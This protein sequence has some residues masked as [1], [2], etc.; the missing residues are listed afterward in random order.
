LN[1]AE[2]ANIRK[3]HVKYLAGKPSKRLARFDFSWFC[4]LHEEMFGDVWDY[5]GQLRQSNLNIGI[6][7]TQ[8]S[9]QLYSLGEDLVYWQTEAEMPLMEQAARLHHKAVCIHP[10]LGGNG[11]WSRMLANIHLRRNDAPMVAW[12]EETIGIEESVIRTQYLK[13][14]READRWNFTPLIEL[15]TEY[16][17]SIE[18]L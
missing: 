8:V 1:A 10:F 7:W 4:Q 3:A 5:A 11:R 2:A 9:A 12:P 18:Q 6:S 17:R 15:Q 13:A 16:A 14:V